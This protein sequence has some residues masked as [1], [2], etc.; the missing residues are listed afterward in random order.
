[1]DFICW[2]P[3]IFSRSGFLRDEEGKPFLP[4]NIFTEAISSAITFYYIKKDREIENR[5]KNYLLKQPLKIKE[6]GKEVKKIVLSK[7]PVLNDLQIPDRIYLP[8]KDIK[9]EY[10]E[11]FDLKEW[12]DIKGFKTEV[13]KGIISVEIKSSHIEKIKAAAHS[14][15]EALAKIEH[16][17]L[18]E[19]PLSSDFYEPLINEIKKWDIPLRTGMW[20]ET[21]F[22]GDLLFFWKIKEVRERIIKELKEDIRPRYVLYI[23]KEKQ[24]TGWAELKIK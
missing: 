18:K 11:I 7:Y 24:T 16:S 19:H 3:I 17:F 21:A 1:M 14:Y 9:T 22:K 15:A 12:I 8:E 5:V 10:I 13:F 23:P 20:T 6:I 2:T 4:K